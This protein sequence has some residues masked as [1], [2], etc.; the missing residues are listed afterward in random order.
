MV[1]CIQ[2]HTTEQQIGCWTQYDDASSSVNTADLRDI[3][4]NG[5]ADSIST[6]DQI[7]LDNGDKTPVIAEI[8]DKFHGLNGYDPP[9][10]YDTDDDGI[11]DSWLVGMPVVECQDADHCAKGL[12]AYVTGFVC[13]E[14]RQVDVAPEKIIR[15][16]FVCPNADPAKYA[17]CKEG[18]GL[19]TGGGVN[20]GIRADI[21]V[22]VR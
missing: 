15:G 11:V 10:G 2:F 3:V 7:Y 16:G 18:L 20:F 12:P 21:P 5:Y 14:I 9:A 13:F 17:K 4:E 19:S 8:Y 6:S 1:S 22:L